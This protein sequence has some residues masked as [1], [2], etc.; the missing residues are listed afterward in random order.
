MST[1][2]QA[3]ILCGAISPEREVS[4]RSGKAVARFIKDSQLVELNE[5]ILPAW[6]DPTKHVVIPVIHGDFG[7]DGQVQAACEAR[8]LA[9]AGC[10]SA[11]SRLCIDKVA[12]KKAMRAAGLP[13]AP[14]VAFK[15]TQKPS[16]E[17]LVAELGEHLVIKPADKGSS[18]GLYVL[19]GLAEVEAALAE[20]PAVGQWM[21]ERRIQGREMSIGILG[22]KALG[23]VEIVPK[24]GVYDYKTKY[25]QGSSEYLVP[26]PI[27]AD[28]TLRIQRAAEKLF[29][30]TGC[31]DFA[32]ADLFLEPSGEFTFLEINTM[33][34]MTETSLLP[35]SASCVGIDFATLVQQM[36]APA[37]TRS[38]LHNTL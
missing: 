27:S 10:D 12:T 6:L 14:E 1:T 22:G 26:A 35:K 25:T 24:T 9:F 7:E 37:F 21:A 33:P 5:N 8:G 4:L 19:N 28:L 38:Q 11:A 31:R 15:G 23:V 34:G 18:V 32:R 16:A 2:R 17:K 20:I 29:A 30:V 36:V 3:V 13:V